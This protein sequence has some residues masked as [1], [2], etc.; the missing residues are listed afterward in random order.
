MFKAYDLSLALN[1]DVDASSCLIPS[2]SG[3]TASAIDHARSLDRVTG[4]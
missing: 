2:R 4:Y 1:S 3:F